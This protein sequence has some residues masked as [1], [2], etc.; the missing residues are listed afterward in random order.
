[1]IKRLYRKA[2]L[3]RKRAYLNSILF[4]TN[5]KYAFVGFGMHSLTNLFPILTHFGI[6]LKYIC[7]KD[8]TVMENVS[9]HFPGSTFINSLD[10]ILND[11]EINGVF[12]SAN[13]EDHAQLLMSL[14]QA[15][16]KVFI[17]KPPCSDSAEL[18]KIIST[19]TDAVVKVGLQR[20][21]WPG[22]TYLF[23]SKE[24]AKSYLYR[25]HFGP[26]PQGNVFNELFIH[27]I[28]YCNYLFG[29]FSIVSSSHQKYDHA[30][31]TQMHVKHSNGISGLIELSTHY[32]WSDPED[33]LSIQCTDELLEVTYP[34]KIEGRLKPKR[35]LSLPLERVFHKPVIT[36]KYF[37]V[38]N[39][40]I[41]SFELNTL[42]LQGFYNEIVDFISIVED[43]K[44]SGYKND[45]I[46]LRPVF[47]ILDELKKTAYNTA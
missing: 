1:M 43:G 36:K 38:N 3:L 21:H 39:L 41:P 10:I 26:Y 30:I 20:R 16:K 8:S 40:I 35:I 46:N 6:N 18:E 4:K 11:P 24:K 45:L 44:Q 34:I 23:K 42:V 15:G 28:D 47:R 22:N 19:N 13:P 12:V 9:V 31:T 5:K 29:D 7:T 14:L 37:S 17:E 27:A 33:S 25:F 2:N 32:S